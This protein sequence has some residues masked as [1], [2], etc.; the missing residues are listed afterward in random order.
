[1]GLDRGA[2]IQELRGA[3]GSYRSPGPRPDA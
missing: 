3:L 1:M 2:F